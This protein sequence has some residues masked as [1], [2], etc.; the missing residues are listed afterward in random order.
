LVKLDT[1]FPEIRFSLDGSGPEINDT[2]RRKAGSFAKCVANIRKAVDLDFEVELTTTVTKQNYN[3]VSNIIALAKQ[4]RVDVMNFH[5]VTVN[6]NSCANNVELPPELWLNIV[7]NTIKPQTGITIKYPPRFAVKNIPKDYCGCVGQT[8]N[9]LSV[10]AGGQAFNCA[11]Y[12]DT[13]LNAMQIKDDRIILSESLN[14]IT[15]FNGHNKKHCGACQ[16]FYG[17]T[18]FDK[19]DLEQKNIIPLCIYYKKII[20]QK[21]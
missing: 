2:I 13:D 6:G 18:T 5:L 8:N 15:E 19:E 4:L 9:R 20:N 7:E 14:E 10:F 21:L 17:I 3:D 16:K 12:F 11:L 1:I